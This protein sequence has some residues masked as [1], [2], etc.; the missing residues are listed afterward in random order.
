MDSAA[1]A[2][3]IQ[4]GLNYRLTYLGR[5]TMPPGLKELLG[6][7][8]NSISPWRWYQVEGLGFDILLC[9]RP[10]AP[11]FQTI[12]FLHSNGFISASLDSSGFDSAGGAVGGDTLKARISIV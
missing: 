1:I 10:N 5:E 11:P 2:E 3:K 7:P 8:A 9:E 6:S 12:S 4:P